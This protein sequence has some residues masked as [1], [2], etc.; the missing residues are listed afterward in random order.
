MPKAKKPLV[1][2]IEPG[3]EQLPHARFDAL[4]QLARDD[5]QRFLGFRHAYLLSEP[6]GSPFKTR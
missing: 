3:L 2:V 6:A 1:V 5:D 4:R